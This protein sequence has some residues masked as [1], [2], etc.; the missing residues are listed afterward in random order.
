[1]KKIKKL[2]YFMPF[3]LII[4]NYVFAQAEGVS[5]V[6]NIFSN[7]YVFTILL[8]VAIVAGVFEIL[9]P[10]FGIGG[11]LSIAAFFVFFWGN[12][13]MGNTN[14]FEISLFVLGLLLLAL[15]IMIPGFGVAGISG[16]IAVACGLVLS[17]S[18][19]YFA[20][21]SLALALVIALIL[22]YAL[23]KRGIRSDAIN[24]LRLFKESSSE[25]GYISV[26]S[27]EVSIGDVLI[28]KTPLRPT[29]YAL[30]GEKKIEVVSDVGFIGKDESVIVVRIS[31]ARVF[32]ERN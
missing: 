30:L 3:V 4:L 6:E 18:D 5:S 31:G 28:T 10:G 19:I 20:L 15:E 9:T 24:K 25:K 26:E 22:G 8:I 27:E 23:F 29:G 7:D 16:I 17:M 13:K 1:M 11:V 32:V 21:F 12:I 2:I 14:L